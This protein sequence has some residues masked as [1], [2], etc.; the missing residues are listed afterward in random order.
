MIYFV[1]LGPEGPV[2][3]GTTTHFRRRLKELADEYDVEIRVLGVRDGGMQEER[4]HHR[5][6]AHLRLKM[7]RP[8]PC[9]RFHAGPDLIGY[10]EREC[11]KPDLFDGPREGGKTCPV[12]LDLSPSEYRLLRLVAAYNDM[13]MAAYAR[14]TLGRLLEEEAQRRGITP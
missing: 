11:R 14:Q 5:R 7:G 10:I 1:R 4:E 12:R 9:E 13:S 6:F 2:K 3:I 8:G